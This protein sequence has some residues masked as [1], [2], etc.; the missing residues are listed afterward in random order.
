MKKLLFVILIMGSL[1]A[2]AQKINTVTIGIDKVADSVSV[3]VISFETS[4][5]TC[6]LYY[7][8][9]N[10]CKNQIDEGNLDLNEKEFSLWGKDNLYIEN[11]ALS[12]LKLTR[13]IK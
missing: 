13:K 9:F 8:I 11:L 3:R 4:D 6:K 2:S 7:R 1:N 5:K 10:D 12:K